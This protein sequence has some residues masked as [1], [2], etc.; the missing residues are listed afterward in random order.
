MELVYLLILMPL[1]LNDLYVNN[2]RQKAQEDKGW[3]E[4]RYK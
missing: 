2:G 1:A 4:I 3:V